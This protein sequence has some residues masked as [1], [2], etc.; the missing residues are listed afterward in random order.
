[1]I[2]SQQQHHH[3][4]APRPGNEYEKLD[5]LHHNPAAL[6]HA[7]GHP[8]LHPQRTAG[9]AAWGPEAGGFVPPQAGD[10]VE[11]GATGV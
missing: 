2:D 4:W 6:S 11:D 8:A 9:P 7:N 3:Q 1:M 10:A 5:T